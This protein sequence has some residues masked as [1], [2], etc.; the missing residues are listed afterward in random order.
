ML[1][2][3]KSTVKIENHD[4]NILGHMC[5]AASK[6]WNVCNYERHHYKDMSLPV[7]Y[8]DWF[9][10]K[11]AHKDDVWYKQLPSQTAQEVCKLLDK[12]WKSFYQLQ[13]TGGIENP[14]PPHYK[15][16]SM[17]IT[18]MQNGIVHETGSA[19]VRLSLPKRLKNFM[20][21]TY[22]IHADF[23]YLENLIFKVMDHIKQL[24]VYPPVHGVCSIIAIYEIDDTEL[25]GDNGQYLSI[26]L[27]I[28]NLMTCYSSGNG[29]SFV[30]GR[31]YLSL[32]HYYNKKIGRVQSQWHRLQTKKGIRHPKG[33]RHITR[34][35]RA[36]ANAI[37]DYLHKITRY[38]VRYCQ[39]HDIHTVVIGDITN[40]RKDKDLGH[41]TNQKLHAL[42]FNKLYMMLAYKLQLVGITMVR[43]KEAYS[44]QVSPLSDAV[45]KRNADRRN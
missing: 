14:N 37:H 2:S 29:D 10:Q 35:Y 5:Y 23:L 31:K 21:D 42:P 26:D 25:L 45:N 41:V 16:E 38:I 9:Y 43:E 34:L 39:E 1:L 24:K 22:D 30:L 11:K 20:A 4:A 17:P 7:S 36:R 13:K 6:L 12:S 44:S 3:H 27:G 18:Y 40:I 8:P 32:C 19:R 33:S 15:Q 28:H